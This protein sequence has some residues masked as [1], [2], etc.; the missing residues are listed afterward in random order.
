LYN[1]FKNEKL[2]V[3][4][5]ETEIKKLMQDEDVTK[6]SGIYPYVLT[7]QEKHL[8]IRSFTEN[9][10]RESYERQEGICPMCRDKK[11]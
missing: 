6:K 7:R 3:Q 2:N 4:N 11:H 1:K 9:M 5:L 10:K 8:N